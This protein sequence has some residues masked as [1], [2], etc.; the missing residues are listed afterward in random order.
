MTVG[1]VPSHV[2]D[3]LSLLQFHADMRPDKVAYRFLEADGSEKSSVTYGGLAQRAQRLAAAL[4]EHDVVGKP[5]LL[6]YPAG[7]EF[8]EAFF[9]TLWAGAIAV[10]VCPPRRSARSHPFEAIVR[11]TGAALALTTHDL[12]ESKTRALQSVGAET[13]LWLATDLLA[14]VDSCPSIAPALHPVALLQYTSGSTGSAKG[15]II[16]HANI[17]A[18]ERMVA[19]AF[20]Q[21]EASVFVGWLPHYHDM[22]LIGNLL[23]PFFL[24]G[25]CVFMA[26]ES[27]V[28][29]PALWLEAIAR[30]RGT[31]AGGPN[32]AFDLCI[33]RIDALPQDVD[34]SSWTLAFV[35]AEPVRVSTLE[36]FS[37]A[38][39]PHGFRPEALYPCYGLAEA[40]LFVSGA[41]KGAGFVARPHTSA[42]T[43]SHV[44]ELTGCGYEWGTCVRIVDPDTGVPCPP[45]GVGEVWLSGPCVAAGYWN[46][47]EA[48]LASF[49]P[50]ADGVTLLRTGD[51]GFIEEGQLYI[52]GR[53][54]NI[55]IVA[56]QNFYAEDIEQVARLV[57]GP[58]ES[59]AAIGI[60]GADG[61]QVGLVCELRRTVR[62]THD[63]SPLAEELRQQV[64]SE[65]GVGVRSVVF[66]RTRSLPRT[67]SG[68]LRHGAIR[69]ALLASDL[70]ELGR[71]ELPRDLAAE[72]PLAHAALAET[73]AWLVATIA[74]KVGLRA[75]ALRKEASFAAL[76]LESRDL[77]AIVAELSER[78][79]LPL[80]PALLWE[81]PSIS[82]VIAHLGK[83][84][85]RIG[86]T[87]ASV[88][89]A[90]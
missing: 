80:D 17:L 44:R 85:A 82:E 56:G 74:E 86:T 57:Q 89:C 37:R 73:E 78:L 52:A 54:R 19:R 84:L 5:V 58:I 26:P 15:T 38:L 62:A 72:Q 83:E 67:T 16:S 4:R 79:A 7:I 76:G 42:Q 13:V 61:E 53:R 32:F 36:R 55:I 60:D 35:G 43:P 33:D 34:L 65:L 6:V 12:L 46:N 40:T 70:L 81:C 25:S 9:G 45:G 51:L 3:L 21:S 50:D 71:S 41:K 18:N 20:D 28:Q 30:Y 29:R 11:S 90:S 24:G 14:H 49:V 75:A 66:V 87:E 22:G 39:A 64:W 68:K 10:P 48:T 63:L 2:T 23:Q 27:F 69:E 47:P 77:L 1:M 59:I 8:L 88:V 31:T